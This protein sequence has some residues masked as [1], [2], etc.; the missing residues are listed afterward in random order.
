V[1]RRLSIFASYQPREANVKPNHSDLTD[2]RSTLSLLCSCKMRDK[3]Q[4]NSECSYS[5]LTI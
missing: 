2:F 3:L 1:T 5:F 4:R